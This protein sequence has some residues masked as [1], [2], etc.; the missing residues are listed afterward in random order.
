MKNLSYSFTTKAMI[1]LA[2]ILAFCFP[3]F[4][5]AQSSN[6]DGESMKKPVYDKISQDREN[7]IGHQ[8]QEFK[9]NGNSIQ[10]PEF[11]VIDS[12]QNAFSFF[13]SEQEPLIYHPET[14][15][16][17]MIKRGPDSREV[18]ETNLD[19]LFLRTSNDWGETWTE[20]LLIYDY[21]DPANSV[22]IGMRARYPSV[23]PFI[24]DTELAFLYSS[25]LHDGDP[26][27]GLDWDGVVTGV[28]VPELETQVNF[29]VANSSDRMTFNDVEF[30]WSTGSYVRGGIIEGTPYMFAVGELYPQTPPIK[31]DSFY[32]NSN[33]AYRRT[34]DFENFN[35]KIPEPWSTDNFHP[36]GNE[37]SRSN[38]VAGLKFASEEENSPG[39]MYFAAFGNFKGRPINN[40]P[41]VG[42]SVSED[43]GETWGDFEVFDFQLARDYAQ[44]QGVNPDSVTFSY[45]SNDFVVHNNGDLSFALQFERSNNADNGFSQIVEVYTKNGQWGIR[46]I[47]DKNPVWLPMWDDENQQSNLGSNQLD[48]EVQVSRTVDGSA[49]L[50]KWVDIQGYQYNTGDQTFTFEH[51]DIFIASRSLTSNDWEV[52][53][54]TDNPEALYR[55]TWIPGLLPNNLE[56]IPLI[57]IA[58]KPGS[59]EPIPVRNPFI[60]QYVTIAHFNVVVGVEDQIDRIGSMD[61]KVYPNPVKDN[62]TLQLFNNDGVNDVKVSLRNV[63]G[64]E[65]KLLYD[66]KISSGVKTFNVNTRDLPAGTYYCTI[67]ASGQ[68]FT[69]MITIVK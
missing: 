9:S 49:L 8:V 65:I 21:E 59:S 61:L 16:L 63:L 28:N 23:F 22:P 37:N 29:F 42:Y 55:T 19:N 62:A 44:A 32:V 14:E 53:N 24:F 68:K 4:S 12:L 41:T 31:N 11:Y 51:T 34:A 17:V 57:Q 66:G 69:K 39:K 15:T 48:Y 43:Y 36:V 35:I 47:A 10:A 26:N 7:I 60:P 45:R 25:P 64:Q 3:G 50:A 5:N 40:R 30:N 27:D 2:L 38:T 54:L 52:R 13:S 1:C 67:L 6:F 18:S 58:S 46:K 33:L 20:P 56:G